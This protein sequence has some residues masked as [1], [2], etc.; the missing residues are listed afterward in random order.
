MIFSPYIIQSLKIK[1]AGIIG[2]FQRQIF[3]EKKE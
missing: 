1:S 2:H 3:S